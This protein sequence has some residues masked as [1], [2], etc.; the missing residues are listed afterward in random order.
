MEKNIF[1]GEVEKNKSTY[2][3]TFYFVDDN[4]FIQRA[5]DIPDKY[6][7]S[8]EIFDDLLIEANDIMIKIYDCFIKNNQKIGYKCIGM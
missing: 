4:N 2:N 8:E 5:F 3:I 1:L 6:N 7:V